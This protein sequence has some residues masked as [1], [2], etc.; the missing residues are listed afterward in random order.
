MGGLSPRWRPWSGYCGDDST[1]FILGALWQLHILEYI[2]RG[3]QT[4]AGDFIYNPGPDENGIAGG[5]AVFPA[6]GRGAGRPLSLA[7]NVQQNIWLGPSC[8]D[9][10]PWAAAGSARLGAASAE[11]IPSFQNLGILLFALEVNFDFIEL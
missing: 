7:R 6:R 1:F 5:R 11:I 9:G 2:V 10:Q 4:C 3:D 8:F